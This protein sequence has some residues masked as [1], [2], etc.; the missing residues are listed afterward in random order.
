MSDAHKGGTKSAPA[1]VDTDSTD[2][3]TGRFRQWREN[4]RQRPSAYRLYRIGVGILGGAIILGG[5]ALIP[6]PGPGWVIVFVGLAVLATEF[7]RAQRV[8]RFVR[9]QVKA[10]SQWVGRQPLPVRALFGLLTLAFLLGLVYLLL[11]A[12]GVPGFLPD[13][14]TSWIPGLAP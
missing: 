6:L 10:W 3:P 5:L 12:Y 9:G 1:Q 11:L 14:W 4:I 2:G 7:E 13:S 8:E